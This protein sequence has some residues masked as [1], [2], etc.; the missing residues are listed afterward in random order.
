MDYFNP[1][2][3]ILQRAGGL[4]NSMV[5]AVW[6]IDIGSLKIIPCI[7][8]PRFELCSAGRIIPCGVK[9]AKG[10]EN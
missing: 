1:M 2:V 3:K 5:M 4:Y 9:R 6:Q 10:P 7:I 8:E